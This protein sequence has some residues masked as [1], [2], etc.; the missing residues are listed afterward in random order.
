MYRTISATEARIRFG[1]IMR[2]AQQGPVIVERDGKPEVVVLSKEQFDILTERIAPPD[3]RK[4]LAEAHEF[5]EQELNGRVLPD[6]SEMLRLAREERDAQIFSN[7][8]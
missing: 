1:E 4:A 6:P 2:L 8:R 7:L 3:W 5:L